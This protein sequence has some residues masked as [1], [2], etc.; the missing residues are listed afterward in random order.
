MLDESGE[1]PYPDQFFDVV[2]CSS[3]IE[4]VTVT[5]EQ[6]WNR[7][8]AFEQIAQQHQKKFAAEIMRVGKQYFVQTPSRTFPIESH[9]WLPLINLLP[10]QAL[11]PLLK[12][13]NSF[14]IK[15]TIP[16]FH[17]LDQNEMTKLFPGAKIITEKKFGLVKSVM[18]IKVMI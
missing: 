6:V 8:I 13:T 4:H 17:L 16:D 14:W 10:H 11:I 2:Y 7:K 15:Q 1:V 12:L 18:A 5:K 3:V 9:S